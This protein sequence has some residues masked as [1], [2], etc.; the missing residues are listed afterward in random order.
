MAREVGLPRTEAERELQTATATFALQREIG[1]TERPRACSRR[2]RVHV[3]TNR[4]PR[5]D[6]SSAARAPPAA[7]PT[8]SSASSPP[9]PRSWLPAPSVTEAAGVRPTLA[10]RAHRGRAARPPPRGGRRCPR[11]PCSTPT[12]LSRLVVRRPRVDC[13][14]HRRQ[15]RRQRQ[16]DDLPATSRGTLAAPPATRRGAGPGFLLTSPSRT[17]S[18]TPK[19]RKKAKPKPATTVVQTAESSRDRAGRRPCLRHRGRLV[20]RPATTTG[21]S[22]SRR[23]TCRGRGRGAPLRAAHLVR[24]ETTIIAGVARTGSFTTTTVSTTARRRRAPALAA[25]ARLLARG[26]DQLCELP[27]GGACSTTATRRGRPAGAGRRWPRGC[28]PR[29]TCPPARRRRQA[30][31]SAPS[32]AGPSTNAAATALRR[33]ATS[34]AAPDEQQPHPHVPG[35][36]G[37]A[38]PPSSG[39]PS[40]SARCPPKR[41]KAFVAGVRGGPV[42]AAR[43][44]QMGTEVTGPARRTR[45]ATRPRPCGTVTTEVTDDK[46]LQ[47]PDGHRPRRHRASPRSGSSPVKGVTHRSEAPSRRGHPARRWTRLARHAQ[48]PTADAAA[49]RRSRSHATVGPATGV[50]PHDQQPR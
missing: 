14:E 32:P 45:G 17:P 22:C 38:W 43:R 2:V 15:L 30:R 42:A 18:R 35:A 44:Q 28:S 13:R 34:T 24:P 39:S 48:P 29:S 6:R 11:T 50:S 37:Q 26:V 46:S 4:W 31:G 33:H 40:P 9:P 23:T 1:P 27:E 25:V 41:A 8:P 10:R 3:E 7:V 21:P 12:A 36:G 16:G 5:S 19:G 20:R 49:L 47:L